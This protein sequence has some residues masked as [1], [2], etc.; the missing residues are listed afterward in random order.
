LFFRSRQTAKEDAPADV[1][2]MIKKDGDITVIA[3]SVLDTNLIV[4][5][6]APYFKFPRKICFRKGGY[7][8]ELSLVD[9]AGPGTSSVCATKAL[10][11]TG[12]YLDINGVKCDVSL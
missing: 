9:Y 1:L 6:A 2:L 12:N 3:E 11:S 10:E 5:A 8:L 7:S 4:A